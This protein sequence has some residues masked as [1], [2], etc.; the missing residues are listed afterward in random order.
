MQNS[1]L[2][3]LVI[4]M[5][6]VTIS[7][8]ADNWTDEGNNSSVDSGSK[9]EVPQYQPP[10]KT[11][12]SIKVINESGGVLP[13]IVVN[14]YFKGSNDIVETVITKE[15]GT[16]QFNNL[17]IDQSYV[18][19]GNLDSCKGRYGFAEYIQ[20]GLEY[21][22][23]FVANTTRVTKNSPVHDFVIDRSQYIDIISL[24][25]DTTNFN[26]QQQQLD[27]DILIQQDKVPVVR[28]YFPQKLVWGIQNHQYSQLWGARLFYG[29]PGQVVYIY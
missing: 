10:T 14:A 4:G 6:M 28:L 5:L 9:T 7:V 2:V 8:F 26:L 25:D 16:A 1:K 18:F 21:E 19:A 15:D 22:A 23:F 24:K 17:L 29:S 27:V 20:G 3:M 11:S 12:F 13:A